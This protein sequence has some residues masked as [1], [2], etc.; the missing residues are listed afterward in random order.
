MND[1]TEQWMT[2]L[3]KLEA[4]WDVLSDA[5]T[6]GV[7]DSF[8]K[9]FVDRL[10]NS[11]N[12]YLRGSYCGISVR[13]AGLIGFVRQIDE[14]G[15]RMSTLTG[16]PFAVSNSDKRGNEYIRLDEPLLRSDDTVKRKFR[17]A[18]EENSLLNETEDITYKR[19]HPLSIK[20]IMDL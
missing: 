1:L 17:D 19:E 9:R 15:E 10:A 16:E 5:W 20:S 7:H 6:D 12:A 11:L 13:G 14:L 18:R 8:R 2:I 3:Q 4:D